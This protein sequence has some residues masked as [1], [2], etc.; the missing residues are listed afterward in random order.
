MQNLIKPYRVY[1][2]SDA[3]FNFVACGGCHT[4]MITKDTGHI[5]STGLNSCSQLGLDTTD[6][7][8]RPQLI[9]AL[10]DAVKISYA[11]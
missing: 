6:D 10:A 1:L 2:E 9:E 3:K 7:V 5:Y 8:Y 4:V 11:A